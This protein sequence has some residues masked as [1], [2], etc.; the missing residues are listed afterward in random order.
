MDTYHLNKIAQCDLLL[1][2]DAHQHAGL[3]F[4]YRC[5]RVSLQYSSKSQRKR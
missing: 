2:H 4:W 1:L 3:D 5:S